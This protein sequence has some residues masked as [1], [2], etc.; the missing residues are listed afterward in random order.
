MRG[1]APGRQEAAPGRVLWEKWCNRAQM[2]A[3]GSECGAR[4]ANR[5]P[6]AAPYRYGPRPGMIPHPAP[7]AAG[8]GA[9]ARCVHPARSGAQAQSDMPPLAS[10]AT[11]LT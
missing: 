4:G 1:T 10:I 3:N 7:A 6:R 5:W 2:R 8:A 9:P 11:P